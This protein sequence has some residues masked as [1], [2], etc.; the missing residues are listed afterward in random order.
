MT[1]VPVDSKTLRATDLVFGALISDNDN[2]E[3]AGWAAKL[4]RTLDER[5]GRYLLHWCEEKFLPIDQIRKILRN[6]MD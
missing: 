5:P 4:F 2:K 1:S 3:W 6:E